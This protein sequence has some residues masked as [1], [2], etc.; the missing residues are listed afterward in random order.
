MSDRMTVRAKRS[1]ADAGLE[2]LVRH[3]SRRQPAA[4]SDPDYDKPAFEQMSFRVNNTIVAEVYSSTLIA[5]APLTV[6]EIDRANP[7]DTVTVD[8]RGA[9]GAFASETVR[10]DTQ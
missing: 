5:D 4:P 7:G 10:F 3:A 6:I 9:K 1:D 2:I 8:W